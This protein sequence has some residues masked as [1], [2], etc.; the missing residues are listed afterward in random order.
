V[1]NPTS[2]SLGRPYVHGMPASALRLGDPYQGMTDTARPDASRLQG[3]SDP[4][5][6]HP[7][8]RLSIQ[9]DIPS[10]ESHTLFQRQRHPFVQWF[11]ATQPSTLMSWRAAV[12][13]AAGQGGRVVNAREMAEP[14]TRLHHDAR[15]S[16]PSLIQTD[17]DTVNA[18]SERVLKTLVLVVCGW[19]L[20]EA[21]PTPGCLRWCC[22]SSS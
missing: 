4:L 6:R 22:R 10:Y 7:R 11:S 17:A 9:S 8:N 2:N 1:K 21:T 16:E 5:R 20:I 14:V 13:R 18:L 19:S 3:A 12:S 15:S